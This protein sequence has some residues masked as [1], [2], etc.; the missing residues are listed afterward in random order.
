MLLKDDWD[1]AM[2]QRRE[3]GCQTHTLSSH[4]M[5][6]AVEFLG[7]AAVKFGHATLI[8]NHA[9]VESASAMRMS[10]V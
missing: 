4:L 10:A 8:S 7:D 9:S 3:V 6:H 2:A 5:F 1:D